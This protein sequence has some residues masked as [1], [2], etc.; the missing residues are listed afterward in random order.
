M[1]SIAI[2]D[3]DLAPAWTWRRARKPS[4]EFEVSLGTF[5]RERTERRVVQVGRNELLF[6]FQQEHPD[7]IWIT[8][9][10]LFHRGRQIRSGRFPGPAM[11]CCRRDS[12]NMRLNLTR[13]P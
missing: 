12:I 13:I 5:W 11:G 9:W 3:D 10:R 6:V 1:T 4:P 8:Y 2:T 7:V